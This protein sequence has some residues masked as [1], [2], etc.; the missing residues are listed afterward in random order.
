MFAYTDRRE[1]R[2]TD[3]GEGGRKI[4]KDT[5]CDTLVLRKGVVT[6]KRPLMTAVGGLL[7]SCTQACRSAAVLYYSTQA[8]EGGRL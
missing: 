5:L 6:P 1:V 8:R 2:T 3:K 4:R 7:G